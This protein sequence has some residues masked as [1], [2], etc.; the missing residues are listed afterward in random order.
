MLLFA[1]GPPLTLGFDPAPPKEKSLG[2]PGLRELPLRVCHFIAV[3]ISFRA[4]SSDDGASLQCFTTGTQ[5]Y[6]LQLPVQMVA[7]C[8]S[9]CMF[10][11]VTSQLS[12]EANMLKQALEIV[13]V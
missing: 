7:V 3:C 10:N 12:R 9:L 4:Y 11:W 1:C 13:R 8:A 6:L 2:T 5:A